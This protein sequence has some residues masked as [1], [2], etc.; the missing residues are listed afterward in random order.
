MNAQIGSFALKTA[1]LVLALGVGAALLVSELER[2]TGADM[3]F[4]IGISAASMAAIFGL[5]FL[6][7][8]A[9]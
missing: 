7:K 1:L 4:S 9:R 2:Y 5:V 6:K 8:L 3:S